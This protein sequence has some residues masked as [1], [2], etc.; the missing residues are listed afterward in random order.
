MALLTTTCPIFFARSSCGSGGKPR[1]ASIFPSARSCIDSAGGMRHP[2]MSL[3]GSRPT[4]AS[5]AGDEDVLD[6]RRCWHGDRLALEVADGS[7][8]VRAE[9]L[10]ASDVDARRGSRR[11][12]RRPTRMTSGAGEL[13][14]DVRITRRAV[15]FPIDARLVTYSTS[16]KPSARR[17]SS[18]T[19]WG[20]TQ[21]PG[22][23]TSGVESSREGARRGRRR[24]TPSRPAA[25]PGQREPRLK[26][27]R[28]LHRSSRRVSVVSLPFTPSAPASAR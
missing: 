1:K 13:H 21:R 6:R 2:V 11:V 12:H 9:Q 19:N 27:R 25:V 3:R 10:E 22:S 14:V 5:H 28:R 24:G 18:A 16:V 8:A 26:N 7:D 23:G 4:Y 20:A 17:S 15:E